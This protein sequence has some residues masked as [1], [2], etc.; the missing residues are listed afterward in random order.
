MNE[1]KKVCMTLNAGGYHW[2]GSKSY[3][4]NSTDIGKGIENALPRAREIP[5]NMLTS[6]CEV[7]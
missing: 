6:T 5:A 3:P 7:S 2:N 1:I 4:N